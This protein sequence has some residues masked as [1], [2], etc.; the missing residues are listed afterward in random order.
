MEALALG[1]PVV[2][3]T[4]GGVPE[5]VTDGRDAMLVPPGDQAA[6]VDALR[7]LATDP[8]R[9]EELGTAARQRAADLSV[10]GAVRRIEQVYG[11]VL[12][13]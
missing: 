5:L 1:L 13:R 11:E 9:R 4:V 8:A 6:L 3:T 2:A 12:A 10:E 7:Q